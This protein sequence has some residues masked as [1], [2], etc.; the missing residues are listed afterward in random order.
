MK[1]FVLYVEERNKRSGN[2]CPT[3]RQIYALSTGEAGG[4][5]FETVEVRVKRTN[6][7]IAV[8]PQSYSCFLKENNTGFFEYRSFSYVKVLNQLLKDSTPATPEEFWTQAQIAKHYK[9]WQ[10]R[11]AI[12]EDCEWLKEHHKDSRTKMYR[13][14]DVLAL[15]AIPTFVK[16][17]GNQYERVG[18]VD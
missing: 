7:L 14:S 1:P 13:K 3:E 2:I 12:L 16:W 5:A 10:C 9:I 4:E 18:H 8:W 17:L 11:V 6:E 15:P